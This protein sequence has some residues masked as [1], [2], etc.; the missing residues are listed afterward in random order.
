[1]FHQMKIG[2]VVFFLFASILSFAQNNTASHQIEINIEE[3]ALIALSN[4]ASGNIRFQPFSGNEAG[5]VLSFKEE[6]TDNSFWINYTSIKKHQLHTRRVTAF[7]QGEMPQGLNLI[8]TAMPAQG[9][10]NGALGQSAGTTLLGEEPKEIITGIGSCYTGTGVNNGH[11]L[12]YNLEVDEDVLVY[13]DLKQE[14]LS[15]NVVY[16]LTD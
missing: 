8:V 15:F 16:T 14:D 1:M 6:Q 12:V 3:V 13:S 2:V 9:Q 10:G 4:E 11:N 5:S 7:I